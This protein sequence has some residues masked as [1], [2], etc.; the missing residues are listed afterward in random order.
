MMTPEGAY[1]L[2]GF[3]YLLVERSSETGVGT[4]AKVNQV[5]R[6]SGPEAT[7]ANDLSLI[8]P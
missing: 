5:P 2:V 8:P 7:S 3:K 1:T 6:T 4:D